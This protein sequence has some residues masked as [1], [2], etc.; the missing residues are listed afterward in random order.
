M[1]SVQCLQNLGAAE[2][3]KA[4]LHIVIIPF[5]RLC[6]QNPADK[7]EREEGKREGRQEN[8]TLSQKEQMGTKLAGNTFIIITSE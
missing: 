6:P 3:L 4:T 7:G 8:M 2:P 1:L 5:K